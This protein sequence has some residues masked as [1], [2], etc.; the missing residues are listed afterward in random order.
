ATIEKRLCHQTRLRKARPIDKLK[1]YIDTLLLFFLQ[2]LF[3]TSCSFFK[4]DFQSFNKK[5]LNF[6][7]TENSI[8]EKEFETLSE[9]I[10]YSDERGFA[11]FKDDNGNIDNAKV[12]SY[13]LKYY[14]AKNLNLTEGDIWQPNVINQNTNDF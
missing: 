1:K 6:A 3:L 14:S 4:S 9:I 8:N 11:Q 2:V 5:A 13:L 7:K 12:V 10:S